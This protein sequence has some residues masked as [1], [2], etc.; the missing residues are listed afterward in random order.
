[1]AR[2]RRHNHHSRIPPVIRSLAQPLPILRIIVFVAYRMGIVV[3]PIKN[4]NLI[5]D[6][7]GSDL[8][9]S[10]RDYNFS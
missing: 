10:H 6:L 9:M 7:A 1:M 2:G 3:T 5:V 8:E 4:Y